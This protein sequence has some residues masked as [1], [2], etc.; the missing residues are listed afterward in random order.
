MLNQNAEEKIETSLA[1][2]S[3]V[4]SLSCPECGYSGFG[5]HYIEFIPASSEIPAVGPVRLERA[6]LQYDQMDGD[7]DR[8]ECPACR[9]LFP[10]PEGLHERIVPRQ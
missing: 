3:Q 7:D 10:V 4:S 5:F 1:Q 8:I 6:E 2:A 9:K